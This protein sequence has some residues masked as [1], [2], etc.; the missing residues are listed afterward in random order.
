M[1]YYQARQ[2]DPTADRPDAGKWR[3]T[4][5][6]D[7][8]VWPVGPCRDD[9]PD[10]HD[11]PEDAS[12]HWVEGQVADVQHR[13]CDW[14]SCVFPLGCNKPANR[15]IVVGNHGGDY[16]LCEDHASDETAIGIFRETHT[17]AIQITSSW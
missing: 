7:G 9:C 4:C 1:N 14:T 17:G 13:S 3:F 6:N 16:P 2:V 15:V 5:M 11:T 10:G 8:Q 12:Q